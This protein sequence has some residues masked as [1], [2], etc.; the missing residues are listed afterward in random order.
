ME[1]YKLATYCTYQEKLIGMKLELF[2][3]NYPSIIGESLLP[4]DRTQNIKVN[5]LLDSV[6]EV[7]ANLLPQ[8]FEG[9]Y[10]PR[11]VLKLMQIVTIHLVSKRKEQRH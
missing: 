8:I 6:N 10:L 4:Y 3:E 7:I 11:M 9:R 5:N 2:R 1:K